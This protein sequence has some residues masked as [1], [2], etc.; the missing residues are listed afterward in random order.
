MELNAADDDP[1]MQDGWCGGYGGLVQQAFV[2]LPDHCCPCCDF[3]TTS[4]GRS[5]SNKKLHVLGCQREEWVWAGLQ[6]GMGWFSSCKFWRGEVLFPVMNWGSTTWRIYLFENLPLVCWCSL[7]LHALWILLLGVHVGEGGSLGEDAES[8][9]QDRPTQFQSCWTCPDVC[10]IEKS[11]PS[12][13]ARILWGLKSSLNLSIQ[14]I[15]G[16]CDIG[17]DTL[18]GLAWLTMLGNG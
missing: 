17:A 9:L 13:G 1:Q 11:N 8:L 4:I 18:H 6:E 5:G 15:C 2:V 7:Q 10:Q 16:I 14:I 3:F 12:L